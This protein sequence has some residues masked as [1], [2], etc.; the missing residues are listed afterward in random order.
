MISANIIRLAATMTTV[1]VRI[2][3]VLVLIVERG[4]RFASVMVTAMRS[5]IPSDVTTMEATALP[6]KRAAV[7]YSSTENSFLPMTI[8]RTPVHMPSLKQ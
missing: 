7:S 8:E 5:T 4:K 3:I 1:I 2:L 6:R